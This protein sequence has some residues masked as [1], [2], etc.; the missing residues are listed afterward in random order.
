M[1]LLASVAQGIVIKCTF[2]FYTG[3]TAYGYNCRV[4]NQL[5]IDRQ[6]ATIDEISGTHSAWNDNSE[7]DR[8]LFIENPN[9]KYIPVGYSTFFKHLNNLWIAECPIVEIARSDFEKP[10]NFKIV[11]MRDTQIKAI[12]RDVFFGMTNLEELYLHNNQIRRIHQESLSKMAN[13]RLLKLSNNKLNYLPEK[14]FENNVNIQEIY[15]SDNKLMIIASEIFSGLAKVATIELGGNVCIKE[16]F[17]STIMSVFSLKQVID[18]NCMNPL[19]AVIDEL[20]ETNG[21]QDL[22]IRELQT[23]MEESAKRQSTQMLKQ[24]NES[25]SLRLNLTSL[26]AHNEKLSAKNIEMRNEI[27]LLSLN[28]SEAIAKVEEIYANIAELELNL[29]ESTRKLEK[30]FEENEKVLKTNEKLEDLLEL[31]NLNLSSLTEENYQL[32]DHNFELETNLSY[33]LEDKSMLEKDCVELHANFSQTIGEL[34]ELRQT[35]SEL[36]SEVNKFV[37]NEKLQPTESEQKTSSHLLVVCGIVF[38][39][40]MAVLIIFILAKRCINARSYRTN[41]ANVQFRKR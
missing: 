25:K 40:V 1:L 9:M 18:D 29:T 27:N 37:T 13:L 35:N 32:L 17:P 21:K 10:E 33:A 20:R 6:N 34:R 38:V 16:N 24:E 19:T 26:K 41:E 11:G 4:E 12:E 14:L 2:V 30:S 31:T 36:Y 3:L 23:E 28:H 39:V 7:V 8:L 22:K 5:H 15:V